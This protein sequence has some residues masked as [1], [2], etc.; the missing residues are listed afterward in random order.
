MQRLK[1]RQKQI[2]NGFFFRQPEINWDSRKVLGLHPSF[3]TLT[4]AVISA[5]AANPHYVA[6]HKWSLDYDTVAME[7]EMFQVKVCLSAG[8]TSYL[9][10]SG[11]GAGVP[12][13]KAQSLANQKQLSA[14][15]GAVK[16]LW[17]GVKSLNAWIDS[18]E[19]PVDIELAEK[20]AATC[21]QCK[22]NGKGDF[23]RWFTVPVASAIKRQQE[24]LL[25][26]EIKTS[27]DDKINVCEGCLCPLK[28]KV[29]TPMKFI[30]PNM[31]PEIINDLK[32]GNNCWVLAE[33]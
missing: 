2:P 12:F 8:W 33:M 17:A 32:P 4:R 5:R 19:P 26:R 29:H 13:S 15:V 11:G 3:D 28:V 22:L 31:T 16:K 25:Q 10:D 18:G 21:V 20:R 7:V 14:A 6:K 30:A 27:Q 9:T 1:S 23:S 24:I